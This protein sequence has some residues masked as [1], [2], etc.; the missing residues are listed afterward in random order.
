VLLASA[1]FAPPEAVETHRDLVW[2]SY[3]ERGAVQNLRGLVLALDGPHSRLASCVCLRLVGADLLSE[4]VARFRDP[5]SLGL[6]RFVEAFLTGF[7]ER[8]VQWV[9]FFVRPVLANIASQDAELRAVASRSLAQLVRLLPLDSGASDALPAALRDAKAESFS[10]LRPLFDLGS[11]P[12][13]AL[14]PAPDFSARG[15]GL[16]DYQV[17]AVRWLEFLRNYG[18]NGILADD[19]GLGK[20]LEALCAIA[21]A[22]SSA[23]GSGRKRQTLIVCPAPVAAHWRAEAECFFPQLAAELRVVSYQE[24]RSQIDELEREEFV[25][26]VLDEGHLVR[27]KKTAVSQ[28]ITRLRGRFRLILSGTPIQNGVSDLWTLMDFLMPGYLGSAEQFREAFEVKITRMFKKGATEAETEAGALALSRLHQQV[29]PLI[30][31]R[32]KSDVLR[33]LPPLVVHN[34]TFPLR[35]AQAA[36]FGEAH[37]AVDGELGESAFEACARER[38]LCVHPC[39]VRPELP[40]DLDSSAKLIALREHLLDLFAETNSVR[41]HALIFCRSRAAIG[42]VVEVVL[43]SIPGLTSPRCRAGWATRTASRC[44]R[45]SSGRSSTCW[46]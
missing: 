46:S 5:A 28:A 34:L 43:R 20:T 41:N 30:L 37:V 38:N 18:L 13:A 45:T 23:A 1:V 27:N 29:L 8:L 7:N 16:R 33:E 15:G 2:A 32:M 40:R 19:V 4:L 10:Y 14:S 31:R 17:E 35:P 36:L 11:L 12:R 26:C 44:C 25:Y 39:L 42:L 22:H 3:C 21:G 6:L 9:S 24:M